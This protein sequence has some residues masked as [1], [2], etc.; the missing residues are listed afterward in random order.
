M[1]RLLARYWRDAKAQ[2]VPSGGIAERTVKSGVWMTAINVGE[3][4]LQIGMLVV[5]ARVLDPRA[6]GLMGIALLTRAALERISRPGI[7]EALVQREEGNVDRFLNTAWSILA[8]RGVAIAT[9]LAVGAPAIA[10]LFDEPAVVPVLR[11]I[12]LAP[13]IRG[14]QNPG[15]VYFQ[16]DLEF[17]RVFVFRISGAVVQFVGA[18]G[19]ALAVGTV[20]A[21]VVGFVGATATKTVV[22]YVIH[23]HRPSPVLDLGLTRELLGFGKWITA[24]SLITFAITQGDDAVVGWALGATALG[25]YQLAYRFGKAPTTEIT[26]VVSGVM[27]PAYS[28]LQ[29]DAERVRSVLVRTIQT[30]SLVSFPAGVGIMVVAPVFVEA[31]LGAKWLDA[32]PVIRLVGVYGVT[33]SVVATFNPVWKALGR[34]DVQT[35]ISGLRMVL[36]AAAIYPATI[37][38]GIVGTALAVVGVYLLSAVPLGV[39]ATVKLTGV[40]YRE[41]L[42]EPVFPAVASLVMGGIVL[43]AQHALVIDSPILEFAVLVLLGVAS[44]VGLVLVLVSRFAW[45]VDD[46]F[47]LLVDAVRG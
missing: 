39:Y 13:L 3:R 7:N 46:T 12:A 9:I 37:E 10:A 8:L 32:A 41:L 26:G 2:L 24:G 16:K 34:P 5:L 31:F 19:F 30:V 22:S 18:V 29:N 23:D 28:K 43:A 25:F 1:I 33:L 40:G 20:W 6:F 14:V 21:L 44:Y 27:F 36:T 38:Y 15:V 17:H 11:A 45:E 47:G 42:S 35:K 4:L